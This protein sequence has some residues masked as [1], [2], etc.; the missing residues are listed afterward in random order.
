MDGYL[1]KPIT[2]GALAE[3][4]QAIDAGDSLPHGRR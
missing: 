4:L 2:L 3:L 1:S